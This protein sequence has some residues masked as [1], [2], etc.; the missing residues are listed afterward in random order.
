[1]LFALGLGENVVGVTHECDWPPEAATR[2]RVTASELDSDELSSAEIDSAVA[3]AAREG[4]PLYAIDEAVWEDIRADIVVAQ[5]LCEVCA[6]SLDDV[7]APPAATTPAIAPGGVTILTDAGV[8]M[9]SGEVPVID[10]A[11]RICPAPDH[12]P[13]LAF[14]PRR[15]ASVR[16]RGPWCSDGRADNRQ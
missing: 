11:P 9:R 2:P 8:T 12:H 4:K 6:V 16:A 5:E 14:A 10:R 3:G 13:R 15:C 1:M 7:T